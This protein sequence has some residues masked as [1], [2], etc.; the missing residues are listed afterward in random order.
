MRRFLPLVCTVAL[1]SA[2]SLGFAQSVTTT[3]VG[4]ITSSVAA[5][6]SAPLSFPLSNPAAYQAA[7]TA[8]TTTTIQTTG[9]GWTTNAYGPFASNPYVVRFVTG[10]LTGRHFRI[11]S[12]TSDTLTITVPSGT[13][14][15]TGAAAGNQYQIVQLPTLGTLFGTDNSNLVVFGTNA[16]TDKI[17][18]DPDPTVADNVLINIGG[19][20]LTYWNTGTQWQRVAGGSGSQNN[21]A[22][23]PELGILFVRHDQVNPL[24]AFTVLGAVPT[25]NLVTDLPANKNTFLANRFP[26]DMK[27]TTIAGSPVQPGFDFDQL[28]GW[29]KNADST[30][31]DN[32]LLN[33]NGAWLTY[34]HTGTQWQRVS[35]GTGAQNPTI[36][37]GTAVLIVRR[38]GS[39][40][41]FNQSLPYALN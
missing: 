30:L 22:L 17:K 34:W 32:V 14:D 21:T 12:N 27:L 38:A 28:A 23:T 41:V 35:G 11:A 8:V 5:N 31:A 39:N 20:W 40:I 19:A 1:I 33:I 2:A 7:A 4:F 13:P 10:A 26:V 25:T 15:L 24:P 6:K 36:K 3:P 29:N 9:A 18:T 16:A 37:A